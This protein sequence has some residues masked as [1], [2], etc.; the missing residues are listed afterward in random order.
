MTPN[1]TKWRQGAMVVYGAHGFPPCD[2]FFPTTELT[3]EIVR[4]TDSALL[5]MMRKIAHRAPSL[6]SLP[7]IPRDFN[8]P[9]GTDCGGGE[10]SGWPY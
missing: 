3:Q 10:W 6:P 7:P 5:G 1:E 2:P 4:A 9:K 8:F